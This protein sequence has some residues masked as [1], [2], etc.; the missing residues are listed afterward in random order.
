MQPYLL[1]FLLPL[2]YLAT[3][4]G[5]QYPAQFRASA[6]LLYHGVAALV[7][8]IRGLFSREAK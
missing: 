3:L 8:R 5:A 1:I 2:L 7:A 4:L 6:A